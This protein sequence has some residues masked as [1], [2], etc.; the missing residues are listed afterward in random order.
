[1]AS[2]LRQMF[3]QLQT[4]DATVDV[5]K[6]KVAEQCAT[7]LDAQLRADMTL[8]ERTLAL[9]KAT[10]SV[11]LYQADTLRM[12]RQTSQ[13]EQSMASTKQSHQAAEEKLA[14][15][16]TKRAS[17]E[18]A[19]SEAIEVDFAALQFEIAEKTAQIAALEE[20][21]ATLKEENLMYS[22]QC[23]A[24]HTRRIRAEESAAQMIKEAKQEIESL[25]AEVE[26]LQ[27][28]GQSEKQAY[29]ALEQGAQRRNCGH[30]H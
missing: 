10:D 4:S 29:L 6:G 21:V 18:R 7:L 30:F 5:L 13:L 3:E 22:Q 1:M 15:E 8:K 9:N 26:M 11:E 2:S 27:I 19:L 20:K 25:K 12:A 14:I 23:T 16:S 24:E 17:I 28:I